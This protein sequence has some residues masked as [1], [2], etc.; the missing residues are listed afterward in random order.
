MLG[1]TRNRR[2]KSP[3]EFEIFQGLATSRHI[4]EMAR[5]SRSYGMVQKRRP[6]LPAKTCEQA[7]C[8]R[9]GEIERSCGLQKVLRRIL[10][11]KWLADC[12]LVWGMWGA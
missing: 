7:A 12:V 4:M 2:K 3:G 5:K 9:R 10:F 8:T 6:L 1:V 11:S